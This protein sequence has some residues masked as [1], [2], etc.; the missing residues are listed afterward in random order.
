MT[1]S[2]RY[3]C[4]SLTKSEAVR[5]HTEREAKTVKFCRKYGLTPEDITWL[6][7]SNPANRNGKIKWLVDLPQSMSAYHFA[8]HWISTTHAALNE[9]A[10]RLE[11]RGLMVEVTLE[12]IEQITLHYKD[13]NDWRSEIETR[14]GVRMLNNPFPLQRTPRH[15]PAVG[16]FMRTP[17]GDHLLRL[18]VEEVEPEERAILWFV[19]DR[20][21][22]YSSWLVFVPENDP[23]ISFVERCRGLCD[24]RNRCGRAIQY[25]EYCDRFALP[26]E[27]FTC[28][29]IWIENIHFLPGEWLGP[30]LAK[31]CRKNH[32]KRRAV[33]VKFARYGDPMQRGTPG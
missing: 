33:D 15:G 4:Q 13:F 16:E 28:D 21:L 19:E 6:Y 5:L 25:E 20:V 30:G 12:N 17:A 26:K 31:L 2:F 11:E 14:T 3:P 23:N 1:S 32:F 8:P 9:S 18:F 29:L 22:P 24:Q 10:D 7:C 27:Q